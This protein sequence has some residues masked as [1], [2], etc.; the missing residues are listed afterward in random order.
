[1]AKRGAIFKSAWQREV[2]TLKVHG[3]EKSLKAYGPERYGQSF[4]STWQREV[5]YLKKHGKEK[6]L[7]AHS[8]ERYNL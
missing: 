4:N 6:S 7:K 5:Q 1:M 2:K 3:K 8:K